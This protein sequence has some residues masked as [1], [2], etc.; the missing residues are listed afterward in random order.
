[1]SKSTLLSQLGLAGN[2][3]YRLSSALRS[4]SSLQASSE[5]STQT[6]LCSPSADLALR[7]AAPTPRQYS[8][9]YLKYWR[10]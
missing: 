5:P 8:L 3:E 6:L 10:W 4:G 7:G 1:V 2:L 9:S